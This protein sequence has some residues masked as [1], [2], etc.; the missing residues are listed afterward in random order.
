V[1]RVVL[2]ASAIVF[3]DTLFFAMLTPLLPHYAHR[4]E[5]SKA[6][7]GVLAAA[8]PAGVLVGAIP[9]GLLAVKVGVRATAVVGLATV[10][11]TS[12]VFGFGGSILLL[13][14]ARFV[15]GIGSACAWT[16]ALS[17]LVAVAPSD[18][19]GALIGQTIGIAIVG[20][21]FG[22][23][24][25]GIASLVGTGSTFAAVAALA[26]GVAAFAV[27]TDQPPLRRVQSLADLWRA[28]HDRSLLGGLWLVALPALLFG[29]TVVLVPLRLSD[30]GVGA[31]AI[32]AV[33]VTA[34]AVE[35]VA[36]PFSGRL[37]DRRGRRRA[38]SV[39]LA[40]SA[41]GAAVLPWPN[42]A[43]LL[44]AAAVLASAAFGLSW[45]PAMAVLA[46]AAQRID[47]H[48][49]WAFALMNLAWA[50]GQALGSAAGGAIAKATS[51]AVPFL[52]LSGACVA[53]LLALRR[54]RSNARELA[55]RPV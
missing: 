5:L 52:L 24:L 21:L 29:T 41:V 55:R 17:W 8:Y 28:S 11:A 39:S 42:Q 10:A 46:D 49:A 23:G 9:S 47:L 31:V 16:A 54:H 12:I 53:T 22:P 35:A 37:A 33:F 14:S 34:A 6:G 44:G 2:L 43:W 50:P 15:Q 48:L 20:A 7:V 19:S 1:R 51:D 32:G 25:G 26:L 40:A 3:V 4:F 18:R 45:A 30:L 13:D 36:S 27:G 38:V